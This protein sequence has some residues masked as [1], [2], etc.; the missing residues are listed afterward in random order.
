[1][2]LFTNSR[3]RSRTYGASL[4]LIMSVCVDGILRI[5]F[6]FFWHFVYLQEAE[7]S[8]W[9]AWLCSSWVSRTSERRLCSPGT[10]SDAPL[11]EGEKLLVLLWAVCSVAFCCAPPQD[12]TDAACTRQ[13]REGEALCVCVR[14]RLW[15]LQQAP[16]ERPPPRPQT[17]VDS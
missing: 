3:S 15:T 7:A 10:L 4:Y 17:E 14:A 12:E 2:L 1:M 9:S 16:L 11:E 8:V 5:S 6:F 13:A